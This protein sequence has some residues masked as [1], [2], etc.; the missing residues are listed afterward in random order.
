MAELNEAIRS[1]QLLLHYQPKFD[2]KR[3]C[4]TGF[5]ALVRWQH[6][7]LGLL[8]P[9]RFLPLAEMGDAIHALTEQVLDLALADLKRWQDE[10]RAYSVA[11]NLS[12][13][14]L[15]DE[16]FLVTLRGL[17]DRHG[18]RPDR[19]ELEITET[20]LM[21]DPERAA[22]LLQRIADLG[23]KLS[24]DDYGTGYS[25]LGYLHRL[26]IHALKIDRMFVHDIPV[27]EHDGII[28]RSTV[29]MAHHLGLEVLAEGV[30]DARTEALL[31]EMGCDQIQ[32]YH[33]SQPLPMRELT[34][35]LAR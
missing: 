27:N 1:G 13:R 26:P 30:E 18:V 28:V 10:G 19:L 15:M 12:A 3:G 34:D 16:R 35:W 2:L 8:H 32:G 22:T 17:L 4:I 24:I 31:R 29:A 5:E 7:R 20:A 25:S 11:V 33:L 14:S 6:P 9:E 23:V 21:H